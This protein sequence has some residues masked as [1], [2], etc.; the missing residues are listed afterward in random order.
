[1]N[2]NIANRTLEK[3]LEDYKVYAVGDN[4]LLLVLMELRYVTYSP[5]L[6]SFK[7]NPTVM[8]IGF[9]SLSI[10]VERN[11]FGINQPSDWTNSIKEN[12]HSTC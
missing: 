4:F 8:M 7:L 12:M 6:H 2:K 9:D 1:L 10:D 5:D 11:R 3:N